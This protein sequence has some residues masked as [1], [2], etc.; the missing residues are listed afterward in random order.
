MS[1]PRTV[2]VLIVEDH[3]VVRLGLRHVMEHEGLEVCAE[4]GSID[5]ALRSAALATADLVTVDLSLG[6]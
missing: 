5:A 1:E 2:R 4:V 6:G 3:P